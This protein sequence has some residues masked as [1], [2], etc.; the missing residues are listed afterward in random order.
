MKKWLGVIVAVLLIGGVIQSPSVLAKENKLEVEGNLVIVGGA[1]GSSNAEVYHE[2]IKLSGGKDRAKIGIVPAAS[3]SLKSTNKFKEDLISYGMDESSIE[4]IPLSSHDFSGTEENE[5]KWK[6]N[7]QKNKTVDQIKE[8]SGIWFVGGDQLRI[9]DTLLKKNGKQTKALEAIWEIYRGGAVLGGT[10]AGAAIMSDVMITGGDSLGGFRQKFVDEDTSSSDEE[11]APVYIEKGLGF[12][13]WGIV[14][15]HFNERS[16]S[17]RLA[18]TSLKYEKDQ[19]AYGIDEDTAM[20]VH[21]KEKTIDIIGRNTVTVVDSS[22]AHTNGKEIKGLDISYLSRGDS[23]QVDE[24]HYTIHEDKV[25][26]KGYEYYDFEPLPAT[27][28]LTSYGTLPNYLSYSL[29][30][31]TAV[32]EVHSYLY[33]SDGDGY[34]IIFQQDKHSQGFWGYQD[35]QKDSYSLLHVNMN[36]E[37]VELSFKA[38]D[39]LFSNY[40]KSSFQVP[41]YSFNSETKG[42]LVMAGGALGS[43]NAEVY[44]AFIEKAGEDGDYAIIPAASSSLKSSRAFTED[45]VSYGVPE[46]NI[47]ILP[48]S[49]HDFKG[50]EEDESSWLDHKN[51]DELAEKVLGYDGVWFVGGDQTDITNSLLNPDGSKSKVLESLWTI[52]EEGAVLGGTSAGAAIMSDVMIA[53]GGSYDTLANGFTDTYDSMSQQEGGHA[54]LEKGLGFFPYGIIGQHFDNKARL[55]RLIPAT[56]AHG[57][58][59]EYSY[60]IDEDTAMIF[61]NDTWTVEVKGRGGVTVVDLS[62]ASHPDDAPSDYEDILLSWITS[63]DQL[64][65]DTNEF[66]VSDH[67]VST[68]DYEYFDYEAAPHSGVLTPHPTLGNFLSYTLLDNEREEEVKSYSFY[69]GKGFELTFAKGERTEGFWGYED[70]N[71]DDYSF[72]RVIMDIQPVEVEIDY[73]N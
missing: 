13:Q 14:D 11:Y 63:G 59:G 60:G 17:G 71:K 69:E 29:V 12:F 18:A 32:H 7:A 66:T 52:Y 55:G 39:N 70:G 44:E 64:D 45:L 9:T 16:R 47:D 73:K 28:V 31:N 35:G 33:D 61:D 49:N 4:I 34:K 19:L 40:Q 10:S 8:L 3:G 41:D 23:Y 36:V 15:Q 42:S 22:E 38:N 25:P 54:Y 56:S 1:L 51:D 72:L 65:L 24:Q 30:D 37:P 67:K 26:T 2:F 5:R 6:S 21:N 50:T 43:S 57:E 68:L 20:I 58:E 46:E 53:G 27:G 48:I 62:E